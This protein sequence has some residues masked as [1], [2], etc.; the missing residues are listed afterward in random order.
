MTDQAIESSWTAF[1]NRAGWWRA[2]LLVVVYLALYLG[3]GRLSGLVFGGRV[4]GGTFDAPLNVFAGLTFA[5]LVGSVILALFLVSVGWLHE[6][7]GPQPI[8][9]SRWMWIAPV[10][11]VIFI[12]LRLLGIDYGHYGAG[13]V[14]V[15]ML[16]GLLIGF[17]EEVLFRGIVIK[18]LRDA[19]SKELVVALVSSLYFAASH[20]ANALGGMAPLTVI[21][22][23]AYTFFFGVL[24]YLTLRVTG[25]LVWAILLHG[26][27]DPTLFL[28][29]GGVDES[30]AT[31]QNIFLAIAA[32]SNFVIIGVGLIL[33]FFVRGRV[34]T[35]HEPGT[36]DAVNV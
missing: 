8:R 11:V 22:T 7:F 20:A 15:T 32:P 25:R 13:V 3:A 10:L 36:S 31:G 4:S 35:A 23:V 17:A 2:L 16:T 28:A 9:G 21:L 5:L 27:F 34:A 19:G 6:V 18:M 30:N 12:V 24:M 26:L 14:V 33:V 29:S 1:W